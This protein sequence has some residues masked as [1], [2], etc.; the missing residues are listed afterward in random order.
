MMKLGCMTLNELYHRMESDR[1]AVV[2]GS[3]KEGRKVLCDL[4]DPFLLELQEYELAAR[5]KKECSIEEFL[6]HQ[7]KNVLEWPEEATTKLVPMIEKVMDALRKFPFVLKNLPEK[8][9]VFLT[10]G[11]EEAAVE[12]NNYL[13]FLYHNSDLSFRCSCGLL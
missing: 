3:A 10:T 13:Y 11:K 1:V 9:C 8:V 12:S 7:V 6:D 2:L 5:S 4:D